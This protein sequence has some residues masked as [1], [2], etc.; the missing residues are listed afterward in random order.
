MPVTVPSDV[1]TDLLT[2]AVATACQ[3]MAEQGLVEHVLGHISVRVSAEELLVRCRGPEESGLAYT[4]ADDVRRL[5]LDGTG[6]LG[7]WTAPNELPIHTEILRRRPQVTAVV[8]AHPP[9]VVAASLLD[10]PLLPVYGAYDIPGAQLAAGGIPVWN[11]SALITTPQLA[12]AMADA[13]G[14]RPAVLLRGHGLVSVAE[15]PPE[16]AIAR[17]VIQAIAVDALARM[18]LTIRSA[19]GTPVAI[20]EEDLAAIPDL[21]SSFVVDTMWRHLQRRAVEWRYPHLAP[22][23]EACATGSG[24]QRRNG[25]GG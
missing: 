20:S 11:R 15:G 6:D 10:A 13:L 9:A 21:G 25:T 1:E 4:T 12:G 3:V 8:H 23:E 24:W 7:W 14:D 22:T 17:A 5:R 2:E 18:T 16:S 19:G